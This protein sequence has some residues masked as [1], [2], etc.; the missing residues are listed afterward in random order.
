MRG[1]LVA[2]KTGSI[3]QDDDVIVLTLHFRTKGAF[4]MPCVI[5]LLSL[6]IAF[7]LRL[8]EL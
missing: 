3:N 5:L 2:G 1:Y 7:S 4:G 6:R 8:E